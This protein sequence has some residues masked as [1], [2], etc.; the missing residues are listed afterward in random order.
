MVRRLFNAFD[1]KVWNYD[2]ISIDNFI[3]LDY[4]VGKR[5]FVNIFSD[6]LTPKEISRQLDIIKNN[7]IKIVNVTRNK[8]DTLKSSNGYV[9]EERY[10]ACIDQS[11]MYSEYIT[12]TLDYEDLI[13]T[14]DDIQKDLSQ[15]FNLHTHYKWSNF[16]DWFEPTFYCQEF[17]GGMWATKEYKLR[18]IGAPK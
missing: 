10:Q 1:L 3:Q 5:N 7:N 12:Y 9:T 11:S 13:S 6:K 17:Q 15:I 18:K 14:P 16:P 4:E 8:A 2:E